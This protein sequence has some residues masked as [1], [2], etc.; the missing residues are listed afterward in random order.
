MNIMSITFITTCSMN[1]K[2]T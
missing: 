1:I 2:I